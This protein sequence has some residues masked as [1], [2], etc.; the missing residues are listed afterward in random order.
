MSSDTYRQNPTQVLSKE[1]W[2][3]VFLQ[4]QSPTTEA[5]RRHKMFDEQVEL[6]NLRLV[7]HVFKAAYDSE[8]R[9]A[10]SLVLPDSFSN[11]S[12]PSL[13]RWL[14]KH[15]T[16]IK[17]VTAKFANSAV[18]TGLICYNTLLTA[19]NLGFC[20]ESSLQLLPN[21]QTL[22]QAELCFEAN[23]SLTLSPLSTLPALEA[24]QLF[25]NESLLSAEDLPQHLTS[26]MLDRCTLQTQSVVMCVTSL[27]DLTVCNSTFGGF[28]PSGLAACCALRRLACEIG[29]IEAS[30][31]WST[32]DTRDGQN[33]ATPSTLSALTSLT[34]LFLK[35]GQPHQHAVPKFDVGMLPV[36]PT[37][38]WM[39]IGQL[40]KPCGM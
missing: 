33:L 6:Q 12:V 21:F 3:Q 26:L 13:L 37:L 2:T 9:F 39:L 15:S 29:C 16:A 1:L 27:Q 10:R 5:P 11:D 36:A 30:T 31:A 35:T 25:G 22:T 18:L 7:C 34:H 19:V 17:S 14:R 20:R 23:D 38:S 32:L 4:L 24:L 8:P 40:C 28:H